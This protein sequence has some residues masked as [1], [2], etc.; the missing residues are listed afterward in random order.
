MCPWRQPL[1]D[2]AT[3]FPGATSYRTETLI[4]T[5]HL[6]ELKTLLGRFPAPE[7]N[8]L[9]V[10]RVFAGSQQIGSVLARRVKGEYG[11]IEIVLAIK[12]SKVT[13]LRIQRM[14]EPAIIARSLGSK[15][16]LQSFEGKTID[17]AWNIGPNMPVV[18]RFSAQAVVEGARS[19]LILHEVGVGHGAALHH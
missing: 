10:H 15:L 3:F 11:A 4:L 14:R 9:Y 7:E 2:M 1:A 17:S 16:W 6:R 5:S 12:D 8:P 13:A 18:A 19:L